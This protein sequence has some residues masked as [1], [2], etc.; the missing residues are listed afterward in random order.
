MRVDLWAALRV[1]QWVV[2]SVEM[3]VGWWVGET[4]ALSESKRVVM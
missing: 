4:A 3:T 1:V 2:D